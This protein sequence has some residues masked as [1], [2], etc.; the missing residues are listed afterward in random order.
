MSYIRKK[1]K[2][3]QKYQALQIRR[4]DKVAFLVKHQWCPARLTSY[5]K[6]LDPNIVDVYVAT[7]TLKVMKCLQKKEK[8]YKFHSFIYENHDPHV[9]KAKSK[10]TALF[11][12]LLDIDILPPM[13]RFFAG[14][15]ASIGIIITYLRQASG[16]RY[17][18]HF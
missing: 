3:P 16:K 5:M 17:F 9:A 1:I 4:G 7:D 2:L 14:T 10:Q 13:L 12:C 18:H 6:K 15:Y 11:Y 8:H